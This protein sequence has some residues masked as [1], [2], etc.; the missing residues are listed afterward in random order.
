MRL[1]S[2]SGQ[3]FIEAVLLAVLMA[4]LMSLIVSELQKNQFLQKISLEPW[5]NMKGMIE[6]GVWAP[7]GIDSPAPG[8]HPSSQDRVLSLDPAGE[9]G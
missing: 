4:G 8:L 7:C 6:C 3:I 2:Q 9:S 5:E 1:R